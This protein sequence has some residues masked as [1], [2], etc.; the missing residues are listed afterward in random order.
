VVT[1]ELR[2]ELF[3]GN[4]EK[5]KRILGEAVNLNKGS[6]G[7]EGDKT[8]ERMYLSRPISR[9][10]VTPSYVVLDFHTTTTCDSSASASLKQFV[11]RANGQGVK[12]I[13][14]GFSSRVRYVLSKGGVLDSEGER[15]SLDGKIGFF[16]SVSKALEHC[17]DVYL[18]SSIE[19]MHLVAPPKSWEDLKRSAEGEGMTLGMIV[20][21][22]AGEGGPE[23]MEEKLNTYH[24][25]VEFDAGKKI[26]VQFTIGDF[27][28]EEPEEV[29]SNSFYIILEGQVLSYVMG[30]ESEGTYLD[31]GAVVG[32]VDFLLERPRNFNVVVVEKVKVAKIRR[33]NMLKMKENDGQIYGMV[34][35]CVLLASILELAN[36][37]EC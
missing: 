34:E 9:G 1:Y 8:P 6:K 25:V 4:S 26:F 15:P 7:G 2:G 30:H 18:G 37:T 32:Y 28:E 36:S 35:R 29:R 5:V 20:K 13:G 23:G 14:A 17:E 21:R 10:P 33:E 24:E 31:R 27:M 22:I 12:V 16:V 3:F 19:A 11:A